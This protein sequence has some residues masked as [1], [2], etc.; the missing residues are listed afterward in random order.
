VSVSRGGGDRANAGQLSPAEGSRRSSRS[1]S[2][3]YRPV[4]GEAPPPGFIV[5]M[6]VV[7][8]SPGGDS[9]GRSW[10]HADTPVQGHESIAATAMEPPDVQ[11]PSA[12]IVWKVIA[13]SRPA[14]QSIVA[15]AAAQAGADVEAARAIT[16]SAVKPSQ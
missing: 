7:G 11:A 10:I 9:I 1:N 5:E 4:E 13:P 15:S 3:A 14:P 8:N 12:S 2:M 6:G 16:A